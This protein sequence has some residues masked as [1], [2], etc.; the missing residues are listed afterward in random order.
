M[1]L[2]SCSSTLAFS[3]TLLK[4]AVI[5]NFMVSGQQEQQNY[6]KLSVANVITDCQTYV[7]E[8]V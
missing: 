8:D 1:F 6:V 4:W 2:G 5:P 3:V 7:I